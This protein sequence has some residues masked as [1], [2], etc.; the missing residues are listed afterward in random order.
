M[1]LGARIHQTFRNVGFTEVLMR[2]RKI[3][4]HKYSVHTGLMLKNLIFLVSFLNSPNKFNPLEF[5]GLSLRV[6]WQ[7][8]ELE[9]FRLI[10]F[11]VHCCSPN[12]TALP[13][14]QKNPKKPRK[15]NPEIKTRLVFNSSFA[16]WK[17][18][19]P[20]TA[21]SELQLEIFLPL[22]IFWLQSRQL[23]SA[24]VCHNL[25]LFL[26]SDLFAL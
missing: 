10:F 3:S 20:C 1:F 15:T 14:P 13:P 2:N 9:L 24:E 25:I 16:L 19:Q 22:H 17:R 18:N 6:L 26:F 5:R 4:E 12:S 8:S 21:S 7:K 23:Q 11:R